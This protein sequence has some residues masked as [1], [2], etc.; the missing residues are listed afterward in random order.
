[1]GVSCQF[2]DSAAVHPVEEPTVCVEQKAAW[3]PEPV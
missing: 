3:V 2:D 1:M